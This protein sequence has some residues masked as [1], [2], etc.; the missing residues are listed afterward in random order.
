M[1]KTENSHHHFMLE[2][3]NHNTTW[4]YQK[5]YFKNQQTFLH[6]F[7]VVLVIYFLGM[8]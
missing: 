4:E 8:H 1:Q 3:G 7:L 2:R 5:L 6:L